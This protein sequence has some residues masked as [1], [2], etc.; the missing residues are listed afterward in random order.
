[1]IRQLLSTAALEAARKV[2]Q[3]GFKLGVALLLVRLV[4]VAPDV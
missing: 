3:L 2:L 4:T 1:M